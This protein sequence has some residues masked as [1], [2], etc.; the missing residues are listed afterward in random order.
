[1]KNGITLDEIETSLEQD[2]FPQQSYPAVVYLGEMPDDHCF[3]S[4]SELNG[5]YLV[6][7]MIKLGR[8]STRFCA[9]DKG[10]PAEPDFKFNSYSDNKGNMLLE[11]ELIFPRD[12]R[13]HLTFNPAHP[14]VRHWLELV[15]TATNVFA[16][17]FQTTATHQIYTGFN[18]VDDEQATWFPRNL[19]RALALAED[20]QIGP[21]IASRKKQF[22]F[23][24]N[25]RFL[26]FDETRDPG[27]L[28]ENNNSFQLDAYE[29]PA[30]HSFDFLWLKEAHD[31]Q[32][33]DIDREEDTPEFLQ[34]LN[35]ILQTTDDNHHLLILRLQALEKEFPSQPLLLSMLSGLHNNL[36][37]EAE[38]ATYLKKLHQNRNESLRH[39][40]LY[41]KE[42]IQEEAFLEAMEVFPLPH[43]IKDHA[44]YRG[45][46]TYHI[47]DFIL[48]EENAIRYACHLE[49]FSAGL[50][51][52]DRL[53]RTGFQGEALNNC[54]N[55]LCISRLKSKMES[56]TPDD[57]IDFR[58]LSLQLRKEVLPETLAM[59]KNYLVIMVEE[60]LE[61]EPAVETVRRV[62][63]KTSRNA[64]C[65]CGSGK[66]YK[67][68]CL[69]K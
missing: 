69:K 22:L 44:P 38:G 55:F 35:H 19:A 53:I 48:H 7:F 3:V 31:I 9:L 67:N 26:T 58:D 27:F 45:K 61:A 62:A 64:P 34:R 43:S 21:L 17:T 63:P 14:H 54:L 18:D 1:M 25:H 42:L 68:C 4:T 24:R 28:A 30:S 12:H 29:A 41:A 47:T 52:F 36:E 50:K 51:R 66:K 5:K 13:L 65:P 46:D 6:N 49:D 40:L 32:L 23:S 16:L 11:M 10:G 2:R 60:L 33:T 39:Y 57:L 15:A 59:L 56:G 20:N 8:A 37:M